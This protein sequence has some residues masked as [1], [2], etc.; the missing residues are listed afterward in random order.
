M[1]EYGY[2]HGAVEVAVVLPFAYTS[3]YS[4][5]I[6]VMREKTG[7]SK[8]AIN[9]YLVYQSKNL[10]GF[11]VRGEWAAANSDGTQDFESWYITAGY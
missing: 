9:R 4:V 6:G 10:T 5:T 7:G 11:S 1:I 3:Y 8:C 2:M